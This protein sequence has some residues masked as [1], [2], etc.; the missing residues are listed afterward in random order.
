MTQKKRYLMRLGV[1]MTL[2]FFV[3][4]VVAFIPQGVAAAPM[5]TGAL[6]CAESARLSV[7]PAGTVGLE[8]VTGTSTP[9][10][11]GGIYTDDTSVWIADHSGEPAYVGQEISFTIR[12]TNTGFTDITHLPLQDVYDPDKLDYLGAVP[13]SDDNDDGVIDWSDL[14]TSLGNL[15]PAQVFEVVVRF[16]A[17][18]ATTLLS[19]QAA[20][21][22]LGSLLAP[23]VAV[24]VPSPLATC[25]GMKALPCATGPSWWTGPSTTTSTLTTTW[26]IPTCSK[27]AGLSTSSAN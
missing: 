18:Q 27:T 8:Y 3:L 21:H 26:T 24:T 19:A 11:R 13:A 25:M 5:T 1:P 2:I 9:D 15:A 4:G 17:A 12:I 14:T 16:Q 23:P 22:S 10:T 6:T 7:A 20:A